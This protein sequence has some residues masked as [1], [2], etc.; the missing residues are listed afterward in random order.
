MERTGEEI[1]AKFC[2]DETAMCVP[3]YTGQPVNALELF[4]PLRRPPGRPRKN[5]TLP[6]GR[7]SGLRAKSVESANI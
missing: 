5:V 4:G 1:P 7:G 3:C 6:G 2:A